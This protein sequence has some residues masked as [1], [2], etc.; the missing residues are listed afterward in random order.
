MTYELALCWVVVSIFSC[1]EL[2]LSGVCSVMLP[3][4]NQPVYNCD[5]YGLQS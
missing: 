5:V 4:A 2:D 3:G 1:F